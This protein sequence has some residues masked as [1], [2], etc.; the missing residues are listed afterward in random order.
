MANDTHGHTLVCQMPDNRKNLTYHSWIQGRCGLIKQN[1]L[2]LHCQT[3]GYGRTL[4]LTAGQFSRQA[5]RLIVKT[6]HPK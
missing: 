4:L 6:H 1:Y 2:R 3:A 5:T